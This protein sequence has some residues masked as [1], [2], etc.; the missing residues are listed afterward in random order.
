MIDEKHRLSGSLIQWTDRTW[1]PT[2][3]CSKVSQGCKYCY[4]EPIAQKLQCDGHGKYIHGF[5][6]T[7][8]PYALQIPYSWEEASRVFVNSMSDLF[9]KE[10][11]DDFI[12]QVFQV[13]CDL[14]QHQFQ[15]LTKR[16][17]ELLRMSEHLPWFENIWMGVSVEDDKVLHRIDD[18]RQTAAHIKFVS[19]EPLIGPLPTL[20]LEGIDWAIIGGESGFQ[21]RACQVTWIEEIIQQCDE[22]G[23]SIFVKQL[24][25][26]LA[27]KYGMKDWKGG[28]FE[29]F[30]L[31]LQR[32]DYPK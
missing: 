24:G 18:L 25:T 31:A 29:Q 6:P 9:H 30:P 32:R 19:F 14:P 1:N 23:V 21:A 8:H 12:L 5:K 16:S 11:T 28:D 15:I 27:Y 26:R 17:K 2:T 13:M 4:A 3:G 20:N 10:I 22:Q 7:V